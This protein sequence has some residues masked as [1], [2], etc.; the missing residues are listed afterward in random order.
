MIEI[1]NIIDTSLQN[2][3]EYLVTS[4]TFPWVYVPGTINVDDLT[5]EDQKYVLEEGSNP[6]QF[7]H[8]LLIQ[9]KH[10][11]NY[12]QIIYPIIEQASKYFKSDIEIKKAKFNFLSN[13]GID[14][15]HYPH[16]DI[17]NYDS[18][19]KTMIY[20][21]NNT[22]GDT[23]I[24]NEKCPLLSKK[25]TLDQRITPVKGKAIIFD[26]HKFHSS[27]SPINFKSR[28]VLNIVF[29]VLSC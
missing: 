18:S 20:Y 22:D 6:H 12:F 5:E 29:K 10:I 21:V 23:F 19:I 13:N 3:I 25:V 14:S 26:S 17:N 1:E 2:N 8:D 11:S 9:S 15:H 16:T 4:N 28:I 24:F 27:S 7:V